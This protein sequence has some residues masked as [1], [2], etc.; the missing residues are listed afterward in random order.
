M[1]MYFALFSFSQTYYDIIIR[2]FTVFVKQDSDAPRRCLASEFS[3]GKLADGLRP[4]SEFL[5]GKNSHIFYLF[6]NVVDDVAV[7]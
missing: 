7:L 3:C 5:Q 6:Y 2:D 4:A 1:R